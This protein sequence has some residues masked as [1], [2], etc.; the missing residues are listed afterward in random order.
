MGRQ[1]AR[2]PKRKR[3]RFILK[4]LL[5]VSA[6][7]LVLLGSGA[8]YMYN[9]L[10][11]T[12]TG[13]Y[14]GLDRG[15]KSER[16]TEPVDIGKDNFSMLL[17]GSDYREGDG[18]ERTDTMIVATF[19]KEE[20]SILLTSIPRDTYTKIVGY[21]DG[22][23]Y[24]KINHANAFGGIDMAIDTV[25]NLLDIPID[26]YALLRFDGLVDVINALDGITVDVTYEFEFKEKSRNVDFVF[27]EGPTQMDGEKA[28]AY[29]RERKSAAGG[30]DKGR[31]IR[32]QQV[33]EAIIDRVASFSSITRFDDVFD[34]IGNNMQLDLSFANLLSLH[35]YASSINSIES[36]QLQTTGD[37]RLDTYG[38]SIWYEDYDEDGLLEIQTAI[39][40]H[41]GLTVETRSPALQYN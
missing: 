1:D 36:Q 11:E 25:E 10:S 35:G 6:V 22:E 16:R 37:R 12:A 24:D 2:Q 28:L 3:N 20:G 17:L 7:A 41:L 21:R 13:A 15:D 30:G 8:F 39:K 33:I 31:G 29:A 19:N 32:Q 27:T 26:H 5:T 38:N 23:F 18:G 34:A 40:E 14:Q 4:V 9:Q